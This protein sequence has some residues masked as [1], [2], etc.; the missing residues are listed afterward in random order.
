MCVFCEIIKGNIPSKKIYEDE[1]VVAIL[2]ISQATVGHTLIMPKDHF[3]N[4]YEIDEET[5]KHL[6][7]V[8]K[9]LAI[10]YKN[11]D[12]Q[13]VGVNLLNNNEEAAGQSVMHY[14]MHLIPRYKNDDL[15]IEFTSHQEDLDAIESKFKLA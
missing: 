10:H 1:S 9:K 8:S 2:D 5:L 7:S 3:A 6:I 15:K 12:P 14:H 11:V 4:L 13:I